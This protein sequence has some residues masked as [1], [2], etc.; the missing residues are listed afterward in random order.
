MTQ[1]NV[2]TSATNADVSLAILSSILIEVRDLVLAIEEVPKDSPQVRG[3]VEREVK[4]LRLNSLLLSC[5]SWL[6][7]RISQ[8]C[9][10]RDGDSISR[11]DAEI[12]LTQQFDLACYPSSNTSSEIE[13]KVENLCRRLMQLDISLH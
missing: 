10:I 8:I 12:S 13:L 6:I 3:N 1:K 7:D 5:S 2:S 11:D 4:L 9:A